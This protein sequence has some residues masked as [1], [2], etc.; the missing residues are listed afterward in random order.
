MWKKWL[1]PSFFMNNEKK[2]TVWLVKIKMHL[3]KYIYYYLNGEKFN[4][5]ALSHVKIN[6]RVLYDWIIDWYRGKEENVKCKNNKDVIDFK[7]KF[8]LEIFNLTK[9]CLIDFLQFFFSPTNCINYSKSKSYWKYACA[10]YRK[11]YLIC[12]DW[13]NVNIKKKCLCM[14]ARVWQ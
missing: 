10:H 4:S 9:K 11:L 14:K 13:M 2:T 7:A 6:T 8:K 3:V 1:K 12:N 5:K